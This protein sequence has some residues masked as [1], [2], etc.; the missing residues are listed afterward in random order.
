MS[1][2]LRA[3]RYLPLLALASLAAACGQMGPLVIPDPAPASTATPD[4][5]AE[6]RQPPDSNQPHS[7]PLQL[8]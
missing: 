5:S 2:A 1:T 8:P 6:A 7:A 4:A 3:L